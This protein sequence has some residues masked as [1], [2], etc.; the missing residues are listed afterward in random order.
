MG[1]ERIL[2][3]SFLYIFPG[4]IKLILITKSSKLSKKTL[5]LII[6][7]LPEKNILKTAKIKNIEGLS[8]TEITLEI[9]NGAKFAMFQYCISVL[10]MTFK[11]GSDIYFIKDYESTFKH[12]IGFG[13]ITLFLAGGEYPGAP[14]IVLVPCIQILTGKRYYSGSFKFVEFRDNNALTN[15]DSCLASFYRV[16]RF[17]IGA[18]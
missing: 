2:A 8:D 16:G 14:F 4:F 18:S 6:T 1:F 11:R 17:N 13:L 12:S 3:K 7:T 9:N 15:S 10:F 5:T